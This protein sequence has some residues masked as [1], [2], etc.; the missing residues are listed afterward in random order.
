MPPE[1][2]AHRGTPRTHRENT[3]EGFLAA[4]DEHADGIELDVHAT[5]DGTVVVHHDPALGRGVEPAGLAGL[6][7]AGLTA[8]QLRSV[9][10]PGPRD[11]ARYAVP[12][13]AEVLAAV[14]RAATVY[15]EVKGVGIDG[16]VRDVVSASAARCA[17]HAFDHRIARRT[18]DA[19]RIPAGILLDSYLLDPVHALRGA[20]ARDY[21]CAWTFIDAALV[22]AVHRAGG[23]VVAWTV[24]DGPAA[25]SLADIG[26]D[27]L[28]TDVPAELRAALDG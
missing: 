22:E 11:A 13:L 28:C 5:R 3:L 25:R 24:N 6:P 8:A 1:I 4:L 21:W 19:A 18:A 26:V 20:G 9:R 15:V 12:T 27:A 16:T 14:A 17:I 2:I 23:R 7:I 10:M